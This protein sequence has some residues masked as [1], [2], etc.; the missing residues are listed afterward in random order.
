MGLLAKSLLGS[1]RFNL[2]AE[3]HTQNRPPRSCIVDGIQFSSGCTLGKGNIVV[4]EDDRLYGVF[5]KGPT[6]IT[7]RIKKEV[8]D[9]IPAVHRE[10]L[11][12]YARALSTV[13][14]EELFDVVS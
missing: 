9:A 11:E 10:E 3:I 1:N 14:D 6:R 12:P 13:K 7:I 5:S 2:A 8:L 4:E